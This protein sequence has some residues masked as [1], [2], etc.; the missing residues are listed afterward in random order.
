MKTMQGE[1][2]PTKIKKISLP[3]TYLNLSF[4]MISFNHRKQSNLTSR[5]YK[6]V[7][8]SFLWKLV[9]LILSACDINF[10]VVII[11]MKC[12][13]HYRFKMI[14]NPQLIRIASPNIL[15]GK[16]YAYQVNN[17][18]CILQFL[19]NS[20][21]SDEKSRSSKRVVLCVAMFCL[22]YHF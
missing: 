3:G 4:Y 12:Y 5:V 21:V 18:I 13:Y 22:F 15:H 8:L 19:I 7:W 20:Y 11:Q 10:N 14:R 6:F 1:G 16:L 2:I 17:L 9:F